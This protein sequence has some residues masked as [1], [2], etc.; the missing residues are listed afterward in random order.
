VV[1]TASPRQALELLAAGQRFDLIL[2]DIRMPE[3]TGIDFYT[4]LATDN[5]AQASR[6]VLM[7][8]GFASRAGAPPVGLPRPVLEKPFEFEQVLSLMREAMQREPLGV[9]S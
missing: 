4:Q 3:M 8:G 7:S 1:T 6:V 9:T 2:C 5:P